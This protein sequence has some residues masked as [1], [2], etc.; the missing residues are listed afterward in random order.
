MLS[1]NYGPGILGGGAY[2]AS[3]PP[4]SALAACAISLNSDTDN[5]WYHTALMT[6]T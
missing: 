1:F 2:A 4:K 3:A 6:I 5:F